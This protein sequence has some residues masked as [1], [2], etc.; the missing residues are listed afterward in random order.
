VRVGPAVE[1][2]AV[3]GREAWFV[4]A[5][6]VASLVL[7]ST[8]EVVASFVPTVWGPDNLGLIDGDFADLGFRWRWATGLAPGYHSLLGR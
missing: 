7:T 6:L 8:L 4:R 2:L 3:P 5:G 1:L